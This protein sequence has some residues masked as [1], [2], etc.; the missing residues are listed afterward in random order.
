MSLVHTI[1]AE[2]ARRGQGCAKD[3][4]LPHRWFF[5]LRIG[6]RIA[7]DALIS[8]QPSA[9]SRKRPQPRKVGRKSVMNS[10]K[11]GPRNQPVAQSD[12]PN[13]TAEETGCDSGLDSIGTAIQD[14]T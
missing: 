14:H 13:R 11:A 7:V 5:G 10:Y 1:P 9:S 3:A 8:C 6:V 2:S 12:R 4:A